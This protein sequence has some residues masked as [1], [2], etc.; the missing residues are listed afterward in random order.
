MTWAEVLEPDGWTF[1]YRDR[2]GED[3]WTR[4]G[5]EI[6]EG[7][8]ATT[9]YKGSDVLKVFT[10]SVPTLRDGETYSKLGYVAATRHHGDHKAAAR[11]LALDGHRVDDDAAVRSW[12]GDIDQALPTQRNDAGEIIHGWE[13]VDLGVVLAGDYDPP[14]PTVMR[15]SNGRALFYAGRVNAV[16]GESGSGKSWIALAAAAEQIADGLHVIYVDLEDHA[17]SIAARLIALG[18][19]VEDIVTCLH[20]VQPG[21]SWTRDAGDYLAEI[22]AN[23]EV[24]L[25]VIDS[26]GEAMSNDSVDQNDDGPVAGWMR[27][28]PR[29]LANLGPCVLMVDHVVK[30]KEKRGLFAIGSQRK[31]AAIDG[32]A[33]LM[34]ARISPAKG[35]TGRMSL[36]C[37]KDRNGFWRQKELAADVTM[38]SDGD[39]V[40]IVFEGHEVGEP[41]RPTTL[42]AR[43]AEHLAI[44]GSASTRSVQNDVE[45]NTKTLASALDV[46]LAEGVVKCIRGG[47]GKANMW[48]LS[49]G[50]MISDTDTA[51]TAVNRG[52]TAVTDAGTAVSEP[53]RSPRS[54]P[55]PGDRVTAV[56]NDQTAPETTPTAVKPW[57]N[58]LDIFDDG[59]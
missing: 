24:G 15:T 23:N 12:L 56:A 25:V 45:G 27:R 51:V 19:S 33:F 50:S 30:D 1:A 31:R 41:W 58:D 4:P 20:Y 6:R 42:M 35:V 40:E 34:E 26:T 57:V 3:H 49:T 28:L 2:S 10:G 43:I 7:T 9:N 21:R 5:K 55:L 32:S 29:A 36:T 8:S 53:P 52:H 46:M 47:A 54:P 39:N 13:V 48:E 14:V 44:V 38:H 11:A 59:F 22:V 17:A 37:A 16:Q 18:V